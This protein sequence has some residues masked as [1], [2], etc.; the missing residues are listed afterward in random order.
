MFHFSDTLIKELDMMDV[1]IFHLQRRT[2]YSGRGGCGFG[3]RVH[4]QICGLGGRGGRRV[5]CEFARGSMILRWTEAEF[6]GLDG[7]GAIYIL[8]YRKE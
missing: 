2:V 4:L 1:D 7:Q 3:V 8:K 6:V 5:G